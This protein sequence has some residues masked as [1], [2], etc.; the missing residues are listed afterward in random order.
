MRVLLLDNIDS[1][2]WNL[3][4]QIRSLGAECDVVRSDEFD[5]K[6]MKGADRIVISPGPGRPED[7]RVSLDVIRR[8]H[9]SV[10]IL[11]VCLGHQCLAVAFGDKKSVTHAPKLM[12]G[13]T[14][15]VRHDGTGIFF[16]IPSPFKAARY[17]SLIVKK[18]PDHFRALAQTKEG[19]LM[20]MRHESLPVFGIQFHPESF[21]TEHGDTLMRN[22]LSGRW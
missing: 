19:V 2:T 8:F 10:P 4:Q 15:M 16:G 21:L 13:K 1:F 12:H 9:E 5:Q 22:F 7:T 3:S 18:L 14:S 17:H 20:A 11:G 6:K